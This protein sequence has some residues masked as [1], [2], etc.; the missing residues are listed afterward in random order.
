[1]SQR[2]IPGSPSGEIRLTDNPTTSLAAAAVQF[3]FGH[4]AVT[5]VLVGVESVAEL[6]EDVRLVGT[7]LPASLWEDL[8]REGLIAHEV[9]IPWSAARG[10]DPIPQA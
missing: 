7:P 4:P 3:P 9:P 1:M 5:S 6:E 2:R 8:R 10:N